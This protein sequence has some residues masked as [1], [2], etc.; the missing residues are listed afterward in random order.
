MYEVVLTRVNLLSP[1]SS[2]V[3][4]NVLP[5]DVI[6]LS[7]KDKKTSYTIGIYQVE[8]MLQI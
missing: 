2:S 5:E 3:I 4:K 1:L 8:N 7:L 6:D